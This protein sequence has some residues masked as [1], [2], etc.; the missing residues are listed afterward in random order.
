MYDIV[1]KSFNFSLQSYK[2]LNK[3]CFDVYLKLFNDI[4]KLEVNE[5][6]TKLAYTYIE[7]AESIH[8]GYKIKSNGKFIFS[9]L[10]GLINDFIRYIS[11]EFKPCDDSIF[12]LKISKLNKILNEV[13][14]R[15]DGIC[16]TLVTQCDWTTINYDRWFLSSVNSFIGEKLEDYIEFFE[17]FE[18]ANKIKNFT[19]SG[20]EIMTLIKGLTVLNTPFSILYHV[21]DFTS[22]LDDET[23]YDTSYY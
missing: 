14:I 15:F 1:H 2:R 12:K 7:E 18:S 5:T 3:T 23:L 20:I 6:V 9:V 17:L 21:K 10:H 4:V 13:S 16:P 22:E 8:F 11:T 19:N